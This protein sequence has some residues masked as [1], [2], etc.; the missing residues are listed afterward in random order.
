MPAAA[1]TRSFWKG[2][3]RLALV[4]IPIRLV[5][6]SSSDGEVHFHQVDRKSKQRIR[7]Q[8][9][10]AESGK[11][12]ETNDI[13]KGFEVEPGNYVLLDE[14][15]LSALKLD[16]RHTVELEQFVNDGDI[17]PIYFEKPYYVLPD[18][19]VA[20]EGYRVIRDAMAA[21]KKTGI[22]Q[23]AMR[24]RENLVALSALGSGLL[25]TTLRYESE[26]KNAEK[27]FAGIGTGKLRADLIDMAKKLIVERAAVF[28]AD[29]YRDHYAEALRDLVQTKLKGG[30][31][32]A[33]T[34]GD[35]NG[36]SGTVID[37]MS[38]L[39]A[40]VSDKGK[41]KKVAAA[42]AGRDPVKKS[43]KGKATTRAS[44]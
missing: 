11:V 41:P 4:T 43:P 3:L 20:E 1:A 24:G 40:S 29:N 6:A 5:S 7:H 39:K 12:V 19:E 17:D 32:V 8:K 31:A 38:A 13:V 16:T 25:L 23:L 18:G 15:E 22:G 30:K 35:D 34:G 42:S 28:E 2:H 33:V 26:I 44:R 10:T 36:P 27:V 37:F 9:V 14:D 21:T